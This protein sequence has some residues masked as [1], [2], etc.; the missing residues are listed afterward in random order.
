I[1]SELGHGVLLF[2]IGDQMGAP[3]CARSDGGTLPSMSVTPYSFASSAPMKVPPLRRMISRSFARAAITRPG[4]STVEPIRGLVTV[5]FFISGLRLRL[6][7][8]RSVKV[9]PHHM[10]REATLWGLSSTAIS[11]AMRSTA[12]LQ[13][14]NTTPYVY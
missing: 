14:P 8:A 6:R 10:E 12:D 11:R 5:C 13:V 4:N 2:Q 3:R 7:C 1:E 9:S